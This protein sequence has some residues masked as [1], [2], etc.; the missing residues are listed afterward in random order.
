MATTTTTR[1]IFAIILAMILAMILSLSNRWIAHGTFCRPGHNEFPADQAHDGIAKSMLAPGMRR[2]RGT[3]NVF[4]KPI[5]RRRIADRQA[6]HN[7]VV[8]DARRELRE[9]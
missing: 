3:E 8:A 5:V 4:V 6:G 2:F 1:S 9:A 7:A